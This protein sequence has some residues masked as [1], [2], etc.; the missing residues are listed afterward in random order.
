M[1]GAVTRQSPIQHMLQSHGGHWGEIAGMPVALRFDSLEAES[2]QM[3]SLA[4]CDASAL[5]KL[6]V[7]GPAAL[8]WLNGQDITPPNN[9]YE[10]KKL[11]DNSRIVRLSADEFLLEEGPASHRVTSISERLGYGHEGVA[12]VDRQ[13]ATFLLTGS[14]AAEVL[15]QT[16]AIDFRD[17][18]L[19]RLVMTRVAGTTC[20]VLPWQLRD[21][22]IFQLWVDA[23]YA[24]SLWESLLEIC[25]E[26]GGKVIGVASVFGE[27][28]MQGH[29]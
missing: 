19:D 29:D 24:V 13:E 23:T 12:R 17:P 6:G 26:L 5:P 25:Q 10:S 21:A 16:C 11:A 1:S 20:G 9:I 14:R 15:S 28:T 18:R 4:L 3:L 7:K 2:R 27:P 22:P 8:D